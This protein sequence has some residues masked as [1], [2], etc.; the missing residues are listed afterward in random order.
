[1]ACGRAYPSYI[2]TVCVTPSPLSTIV[3][4][5]LPEAYSANTLVIDN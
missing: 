5:V 4:V 3:P 2:G 1:M